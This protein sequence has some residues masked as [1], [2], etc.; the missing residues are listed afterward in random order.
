MF[1]SGFFQVFL[2]IMALV[3]NTVY[4]VTE[5]SLTAF[6]FTAW[7]WI[8]IILGVIL[9]SAAASVVSG[10]WWGRLV[11]ALV[12]GLALLENLIFLPAYPIWGIAAIVLSATVIYALLV[13]G[14]E[15]RP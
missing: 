12:A 4:V 13:K 6:N 11:G 14:G 2:G 10:R 7:G 8:H 1:I 9:L 15:A 3:N 5:K